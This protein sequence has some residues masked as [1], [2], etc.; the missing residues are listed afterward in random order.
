MAHTNYSAWITY[1]F[2]PLGYCYGPGIEISDPVDLAY[3]A[4]V[5]T[6]CTTELSQD[7]WLDMGQRWLDATYPGESRKIFECY[8]VDYE[9]PED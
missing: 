9:P 3:F 6:V 5:G 8:S 1:S 2:D 7:D 4:P